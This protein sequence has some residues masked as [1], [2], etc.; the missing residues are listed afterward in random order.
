[1]TA[2]VVREVSP[3]L[4]QWLDYHVWR[5]RIP[6][7]Q[8]A[9]RVKGELLHSS[10]HGKAHLD[11]GSDLKTTHLMR[12][13]SHSKT[14]T[15]VAVQ[16]LVASGQLRLDDTVG[17]H[18]GDYAKTDVA[19]V[20]VRELLSHTG[21]II[22]DGVES[23]H[24]V[25]DYDFPTGSELYATVRD[26][27][28][29]VPPQAFFKYSNIGYGVLGAIIERVTGQGFEQYCQ[30]AVVE[31]LGLQATYPDYT[32]NIVGEFAQTYS[33]PKKPDYKRSCYKQ[34]HTGALTAATGFVATAEDLTAF[35]ASLAPGAPGLLTDRQRLELARPVSLLAKTTEMESYGLGTYTEVVGGRQMVGHSGGWT[36][37]LS[38]CAVD[39]ADGLCVAVIG[40]SLDAPVHQ[41]FAGILQLLELAGQSAKPWQVNAEGVD[42]DR[43]VGRFESDWLDMDVV[44]C[45]DRLLMIPLAAIMPKAAAR[46]LRVV[47]ESALRQEDHDTLGGACE[48]MPFE[49]AADGQAVLRI[50]GESQVRTVQWAKESATPGATPGQAAGAGIA[51]AGLTSLEPASAAGGVA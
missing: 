35:Y 51:S 11:E 15:A 24:W 40:N 18:L 22:R 37:T 38:R 49:I 20:T 8:V 9:I 50:A 46:E 26:H 36:G 4:N 30:E 39:F 45:N 1:M 23:D 5:L 16:V 27:G 48:D 2:D 47:S 25:Q 17:Q 6:G 28:A 14:F 3:Y 7:L 34:V 41:V 42:L 10:A 43:F 21:G 13:A 32:D 44:R 31:P 33:R 29:Q 19:G 12:V